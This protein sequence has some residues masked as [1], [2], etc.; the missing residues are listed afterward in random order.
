M[1]VVSV[2][3]EKPEGE[4]SSATMAGESLFGV[5][6]PVVC[7]VVAG[8]LLE[9]LRLAFRRFVAGQPGDDAMKFQLAQQLNDTL[10]LS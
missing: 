3:N 5:H 4:S 1:S 9:H 6:N 8:V 2:S 10:F 7:V